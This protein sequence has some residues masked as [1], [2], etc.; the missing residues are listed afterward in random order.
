MLRTVLLI[1]FKLLPLGDAL[2][3]CRIAGQPWRSA[4]ESCEME[5]VNQRW[6]LCLATM[7]GGASAPMTQNLEETAAC[8]IYHGCCTLRYTLMQAVIQFRAEDGSAHLFDCG[9]THGSLLNKK[10]LKP[11]VF[12]PLQ[13]APPLISSFAYVALPASLQ[14]PHVLLPWFSRLVW[15][16]AGS[17]ISF[18][19]EKNSCVYL[20]PPPPHLPLKCTNHKSNAV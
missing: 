2:A 11:R 5:V 8:M 12:A 15:Q 18:N 16:V 10:R 7:G 13:Y 3:L 19:P 6:P 4:I 1:T 9:S 17:I 20:S 14:L